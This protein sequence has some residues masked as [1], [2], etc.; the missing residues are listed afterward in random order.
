MNILMCPLH[1][2]IDS[3]FGGEVGW[4]FNIL[5]AA[6]QRKDTAVAAI[7]ANSVEKNLPGN[8]TV[9][10]VGHVNGSLMDRS[11]FYYETYRK[12]KD[13]VKQAD[14]VHHVF[15]FGY[16]LGFEPL[17]LTDRLGKKPLIVGP[18]QLPQTA[19]GVTDYQLLSGGKDEDVRISYQ[20]NKI[21]SSGIK[22]IL[23]AVQGQTLRR[24][25][26]VVFDSKKSADLYRLNY[27]QVLSMKKVEI[28]PPGIETKLFMER[29]FSKND[30]F[31]V[32]SVGF[33]LERKGFQDL[34]EAISLLR[35]KLD[36]H[37]KLIGD[38]PY[39]NELRDLVVA[40]Q[41]ENDV[42][43]VGNVPRRRLAAHYASCDVF[44][45]PSISDTFTSSIR[46]AMSV[47]RPVIATDFGFVTEHITDGMNG[48]VIEKANPI[49]LADRL[50]N[51]AND[52][53]LSE[54]IGRQGA[55]YCQSVFD[56]E[57]LGARWRDIYD[58]NA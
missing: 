24:S 14:L 21:A 30:R 38:G 44:V 25:N 52:R 49:M 54:R 1:T 57:R 22:P 10:E 39:L 13:L 9:H 2:L 33:M 36:I 18:I 40:K 55:A 51:L 27:P 34:I 37:L 12:S 47:G 48:Y 58:I 17:S 31:E 46:E 4:A 20:M 3:N 6:S 50:M 42:E 8:I 56:W 5:M 26:V 7:C 19:L 43:L 32:L 45:Q 28:V 41:L 53:S 15:P 35:G 11:L 16:R 23:Q 29:P